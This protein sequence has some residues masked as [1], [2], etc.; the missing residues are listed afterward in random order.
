MAILTVDFETISVSIPF[1]TTWKI[2]EILN[3]PEILNKINDPTNNPTSPIRV[4]INA[5]FAASAADLFS[6]QKPMSK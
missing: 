5:F 1:V 2:S 6:Y 3:V 4:V